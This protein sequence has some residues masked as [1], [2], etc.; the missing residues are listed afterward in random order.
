MK[1][2]VLEKF[3]DK[4]NGKIYKVGD[5]ITVSKERFEEILTV[6]KLVEEYKEPAKK[7]A[8]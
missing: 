6:G 1:A 3:K 4:K 5:I 8:E 2:K 7:E